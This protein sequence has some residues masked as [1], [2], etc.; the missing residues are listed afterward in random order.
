METTS[1]ES[2]R[3]GE[4]CAAS[5]MW[6]DLYV[7]DKKNQSCALYKTHIDPRGAYFCRPL[8]IKRDSP[9]AL[10]PSRCHPLPPCFC[11]TPSA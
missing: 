6:R 2:E 7:F 10:S 1:R 11:F 3:E 4:E 8:K 9:Q 5:C